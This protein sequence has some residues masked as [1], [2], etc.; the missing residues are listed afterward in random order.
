VWQYKCHSYTGTMPPLAA[1]SACC[2][3]QEQADFFVANGW[4]KV[5][6]AVPSNL[7]ARWVE[8]AC[9]AHGVD[10]GDPH[11]WGDPNDSWRPQKFVDIRYKLSAPMVEAAPLLHAAICQLCGGADRVVQYPEPLSSLKLDAAFNINYDQ[12]ADR[13]WEE[14]HPADG[15]SSWHA[16]GDFVHY[17]DSPEAGLF[18]IVLWGDVEQQA[19]PTYFSPDSV[20]P[21][22]RT[23]LRNPQGLSAKQLNSAAHNPKASCREALPCVG[24]AGDAFLM[25]PN[26]LHSSSQNVKRQP[27]FMRND[28]VQLVRSFRFDPMHLSP[29]ELCTLRNLGLDPRYGLAALQRAGFRPPPDHARRA[30]DADTGEVLP[31]RY[32]V[33]PSFKTPETERGLSATMYGSD[34]AREV[35][36]AEGFQ[37]ARL[38]ARVVPLPR[39]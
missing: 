28:Q 29:V 26:M 39:L 7:C 20:A 11:T 38:G 5:P 22:L 15:V 12:G 30:T 6:G 34:K 2:F 1:G 3:T 17:L 4:L 19:G 21:I 13:P 23:L 24:K 37:G 9:T 16:D 31:W 27:R 33:R 36:L 25:M 14:P 18:F 10:I 35:A 8:A 32:K